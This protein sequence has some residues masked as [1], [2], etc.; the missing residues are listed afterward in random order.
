MKYNELHAT[1][2][3][4][5]LSNKVQDQP[6]FGGKQTKQNTMVFRSLLEIMDSVK[7][8]NPLLTIL[9]PNLPSLQFLVCPS[10][11]LFTAAF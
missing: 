11:T 8:K 2:G 4:V 6:D 5:F 7:V 9:L 1:L 10:K 3:Q